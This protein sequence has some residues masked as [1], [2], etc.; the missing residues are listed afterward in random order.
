MEPQVVATD[1]IKVDSRGRTT[2]SQVA[3][4]GAYKASRRSDGSILLEPMF[5]LREIVQRQ[6]R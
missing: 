4:E 6:S 5:T 3:S 2:M 1:V